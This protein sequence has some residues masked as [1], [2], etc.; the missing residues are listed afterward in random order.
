MRY[1]RVSYRY[2]VILAPSHRLQ[3]ADVWLAQ[4]PAVTP[5]QPCWRPSTDVVETADAIHLTVELAGVDHEAVEV[6]LFEDALII[7]GQRRLPP[8]RPGGVY[9]AAEIRQGPFRLELPL[10]TAIDPDR[11]DAH[12]EDGLLEMTLPK[13]N[14]RA[15]PG[16]LERE[17]HGA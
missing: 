4:S 13:R 14:G 15:T 2:G 1:R 7:E 11:V 5:A 8:L 17:H 10:P 12:Y 9:H 3:R 16:E 6:L